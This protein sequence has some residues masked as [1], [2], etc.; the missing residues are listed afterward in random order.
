MSDTPETKV[1]GI[2]FDATILAEIDSYAKRHDLNRSQVVR[3]A[4]R[5]FLL[6]RRSIPETIAEMDRT[7][8]PVNAAE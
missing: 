6:T 1:A 4:V 2:V 5:L 8:E 3:Q 7:E